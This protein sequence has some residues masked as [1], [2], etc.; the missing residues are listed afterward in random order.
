MLFINVRSKSGRIQWQKTNLQERTVNIVRFVFV[1]AAGLSLGYALTIFSIKKYRARRNR[2][3]LRFQAAELQRLRRENIARLLY[4]T[5]FLNQSFFNQYDS[6]ECGYEEYNG[7][8]KIY[9]NGL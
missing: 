5:Q 2:Q 6:E 4:D 1:F 3:E 7:N 9:R 8:C